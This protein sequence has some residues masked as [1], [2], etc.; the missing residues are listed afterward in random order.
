MWPC[1][2]HV[3]LLSLSLACTEVTEHKSPPKFPV[4]QYMPPPDRRGQ[5][6]L[7][8]S[9]LSL[10][11]CLCA[12]VCVPLSGILA[13]RQGAHIGIPPTL[14]LCSNAHRHWVPSLW[15]HVFSFLFIATVYKE[16]LIATF[17]ALTKAFFPFF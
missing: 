7:K 2:T 8:T 5:R 14:V 9:R 12:F 3:A 13:S 4:L 10:S 11:R 1:W 15:L 16:I 17:V 6:K